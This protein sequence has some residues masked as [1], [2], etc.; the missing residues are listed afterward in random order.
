[1]LLRS[2]FEQQDVSTSEY[3]LKFDLVVILYWNPTDDQQ[4]GI[5]EYGRAYEKDLHYRYV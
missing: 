2:E 1:M 3:Q 4:L 5:S